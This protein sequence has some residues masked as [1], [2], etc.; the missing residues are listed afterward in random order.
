MRV[1]AVMVSLCSPAIA[2]AAS[3]KGIEGGSMAGAILQ[4]MASLAVVIG[5]IFL[6][7]YI[8][9]RWFKGMAGGRGGSG[10]IRVVETRYLAPKRS[11]MLVEV[12]GEYLLLGNGSEGVRLIKKLEFADEFHA[13]NLSLPP[14]PTPEPFRQQF[15]SLLEKAR[16]GYQELVNSD[17]MIT[18]VL[19]EK[20]GG[21]K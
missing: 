20:D 16:A 21:C 2:C 15:D 11:L 5:I 18:T 14:E 4:M 17:L 12:A 13:H 9:N 3:Q 7:Y 10:R 1:P 19:S 8:S 6:L